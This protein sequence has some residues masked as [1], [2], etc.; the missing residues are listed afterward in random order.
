[1]K[2][3]GANTKTKAK[4]F[5]KWAG[6]KTQLLHTFSNY[7]P[8]ALQ[9]GEIKRYVEPFIGSGAVLF[10][11]GQT[12]ELDEIH[13]VDI[14]PELITLYRVIKKNVEPLITALQEKEEEFLS[15]PHGSEERK[16]CY[17][18]V[19]ENFNHQIDGITDIYHENNV[20]R[21]MQFIFLNR[22]CFNGLFRV[23][24]K[25]HYNVP[26][27]DYK[28]PTICD[29]DNLRAVHDFLQRV[30]IHL[31][32][33]RQS[34]SLIDKD[35]FVY[36]DPPY[37]PL[38]VTSSF[39]SYSKF[40]FNDHNQRE[41]AHYYRE[42]DKSG[43]KLMLSNSDPKNVNEEDNFF[44]D[45]YEDYHINRVAARRNINSKGS[46]RGQVSELLITNYNAENR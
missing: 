16:A 25:G 6:G 3:M 8:H 24:K 44:D 27:G 9:E 39:T 19:R 41:L 43:A 46:G 29:A 12:F 20:T 37:R 34:R 17:Y 1:M 4:P 21:A 42:L 23:N 18:D 5:L 13:M 22:T 40:E 10:D 31:G 15:Y 14:N 7:Y 30:E 33:Y 28:S 45:L 36:F 2:N 32:D 26:M 11:I 38:N 35:T